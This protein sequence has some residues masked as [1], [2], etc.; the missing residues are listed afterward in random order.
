M[1]QH[2]KEISVD[3]ETFLKSSFLSG[4]RLS[5]PFSH[6]SPT[7]IKINKSICQ[8]PPCLLPLPYPMR[9]YLSSCCILLGPI[10]VLEDTHCCVLRLHPENKQANQ[11]PLCHRAGTPVGILMPSRQHITSVVIIG[12]FS[13]SP[14]FIF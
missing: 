4:D 10:S 7:D 9:K 8:V 6:V 2:L 5:M 12:T 13:V 14:H 3:Q 1:C 11:K